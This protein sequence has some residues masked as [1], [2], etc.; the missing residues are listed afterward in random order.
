M[1]RIVCHPIGNKQNYMETLWYHLHLVV[2]GTIKIMKAIV[3]NLFKMSVN[4]DM[5]ILWLVQHIST[6]PDIEIPWPVH[7]VSSNHDI[8][9]QL[10]AYPFSVNIDIWILWPVH[11]VFLC[12]DIRI[13]LPLHHVSVNHDIRLYDLFVSLKIMTSVFHDLFT[14]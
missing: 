6:Y 9:I 10:A 7:C 13:A 8:Q 14:L 1:D 2:I 5:W 4:R 12:F 11:H 3:H